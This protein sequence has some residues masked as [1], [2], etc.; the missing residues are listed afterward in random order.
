MLLGAERPS[1]I[2][3]SSYILLC[4]PDPSLMLLADANTSNR[5]CIKRVFLV[6]RYIDMTKLCA[7]LAT[8]P[9]Y[10]HH[11]SL[12][13]STGCIIQANLCCFQAQEKIKMIQEMYMSRADEI[14]M[15]LVKKHEA[16]QLQLKQDKLDAEKLLHSRTQEMTSEIERLQKV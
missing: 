4:L 6:A 2:M 11:K 9:D 14:N 5:V 10:N 7:L 13:I 12:R 15:Q 8:R 16:A 3:M 1:M